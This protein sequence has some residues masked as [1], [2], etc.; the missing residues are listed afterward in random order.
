MT[1]N[2]RRAPMQGDGLYYLRVDDPRRKG[3]HEPGTIA[4]WEHEEAWLGYQRRFS[5]SA[6]DQDA[7]MVARR[8][9]FSY[10][11]AT[12]YLGHEPTTWAPRAK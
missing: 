4:W 2:P 3:S 6:R 11:E 12:E 9:G 1:N 8:G 5:S 10:L 7:E